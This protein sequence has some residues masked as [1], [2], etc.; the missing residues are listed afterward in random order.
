MVIKLET[1][2]LNVTQFGTA[3]EEPA[4]AEIECLIGLIRKGNAGSLTKARNVLGIERNVLS[5][6][7]GISENTLNAWEIGK[8]V[9][10]Q[11]YLIAWRLKLGDYIEGKV[12]SYL[13]TNDP[14]LIH[15]FWEIVWRLNDL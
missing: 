12:A 3:G 15:Q 11:K 6:R 1:E 5:I 7:I 14:E 13:R 8:E 4:L 9:P 2:K 10:P